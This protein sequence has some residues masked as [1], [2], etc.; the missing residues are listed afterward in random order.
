LA[1]LRARQLPAQLARYEKNT[2]PPCTVETQSMGSLLER[3][4]DWRQPIAKRHRMA[5]VMA[6]LTLACLSGVG[7]G[8]RA[9]SRFSK[10]LTKGQRRQLKCWIHPD[11]GKSHVPSEAVF[12]RL[13]QRVSRREIERIAI[14]W[15]KDVLGAVPATDALVIDGKADWGQRPI[16]GHLAGGFTSGETA[17]RG[18]V[19]AAGTTTLGHREPGF[20]PCP[21]CPGRA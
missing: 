1:V 9:V 8:Y 14:Q 20:Q 13:L 19:V 15:Q 17:Q 18:R 21:H 12:Q 6:I 10:R 5:T 4:E 16:D 11:T 7:Q 3:L 2:P